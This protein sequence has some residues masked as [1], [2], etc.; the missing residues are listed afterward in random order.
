MIAF[1]A[2][3][4]E[5]CTV[6][7][8][9]TNTPLQALV[10]LNDPQFVEAARVMAERIQKEGGHNPKDQMILAFRLSTGRRPKPKEIDMFKDLYQSQYKM[11]KKNPSK[12]DELLNVGEYRSGHPFDKLKTAALTMVTSTMLNHDESYMKR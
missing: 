12:A 11:F 4:R 6:K 10:L 8:E 7:R 3:S 5:V 9:T 1:D 2:G